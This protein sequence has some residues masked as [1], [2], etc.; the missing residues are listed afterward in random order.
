MLWWSSNNDEDLCWCVPGTCE[1]SYPFINFFS[2]IIFIFF[3]AALRHMEF[4]GQGSDLSCSCDLSCICSNA[5]SLTH[6]AGPG[7]EP[8]SQSAPK[9][10]A[11]PLCQSRNSHKFFFFFGLFKVAPMAYGGSQARGRIGAL[12]TGPCQSHSHARSEL[13]LRPTLQLTAMP[14][15]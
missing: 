12:A 14:D 5:R 2:F 9:M 13:H 11:I 8:V 3:L 10:P 7:I 6:C 1:I 15:P 4:P